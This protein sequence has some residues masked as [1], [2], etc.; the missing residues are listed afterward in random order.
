MI[1]ELPTGDLPHADHREP[2]RC[3]AG[4]SRALR[5]AQRPLRDALGQDREEGGDA[6]EGDQTGVVEAGGD[7]GLLATTQ[8]QGVEGGF[9]IAAV[10][11][12]C[13]G[14]Q[15]PAL[16]VEGLRV[17]FGEAFEQR[18]AVA[19]EAGGLGLG[20]DR[21]REAHEDGAVEPLQR[22][23]VATP[24]EQGSRRFG[25]APGQGASRQRVA[26]ALLDRR[27]HARSLSTSASKW[28]RTS[29]RTQV[30][31]SSSRVCA[32]AAAASW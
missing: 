10:A 29:L 1:G 3:R 31:S 11:L 17:G 30:Q 21:A 8:A 12:G 26:H 28:V 13:P 19:E 9:Q 25:E 2:E 6:L 23:V 5:E 15:R 20:G 22:C 24:L 4:G 7:A 32:S 16:A 18:R 14:G 27:P